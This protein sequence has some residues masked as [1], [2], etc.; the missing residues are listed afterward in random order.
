MSKNKFTNAFANALSKSTVATEPNVQT[1]KRP[2]IQTLESPE[3]PIIM[4]KEIII[5][6]AIKPE[7]IVIPPVKKLSLKEQGWLPT[8]I[9]LPPNIKQN[10]QLKSI[11]EGR[12][13]SE[14]VA[15]LLS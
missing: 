13:M 10:L 3:L 1:F 12:D 14:I 5:V 15:G 2:N 4:K 11:N 7:T 9:Y 6:K 8:T